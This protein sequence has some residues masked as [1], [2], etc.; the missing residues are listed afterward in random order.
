MKK[1]IEIK[2]KIIKKALKSLSII[3]VIVFV[4]A[5]NGNE[6]CFIWIYQPK[7]P[8]EPKNFS[9]KDLR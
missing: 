2:Q 5:Q 3:S 4:A 6:G 1:I 7:V 8:Q 9:I